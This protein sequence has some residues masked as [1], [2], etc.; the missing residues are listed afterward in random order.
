[1][2]V[3]QLK[4]GEAH[5]ITIDAHEVCVWLDTEVAEFDGLC[6]GTGQTM[7]QA[8]SDASESLRLASQ[9]IEAERA[10]LRAEFRASMVRP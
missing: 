2:S 9:A 6:I 10:R 3:R 5:R 4:A 1:M 8:L 7:A